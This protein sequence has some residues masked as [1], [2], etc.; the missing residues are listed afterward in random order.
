MQRCL[1]LALNGKNTVSPNPMVGSVIVH[2]NK[3]IGEGWH[4]RAG[5]PHAEVNAIKSVK[6][7]ALLK[8]STL[9]VS[10]EPC[11]HQGKTPPC[12]SLI[13]EKEIPRVVVACRDVHSAVNGRGIQQLRDHGVEVCEGVLEK[14]ALAL[15]RMFFTFHSQKRPYILL[16]WAQTLDGFLDRKREAHELGINWITQPNTRSYVH[17]VRS[18]FDAILVGAQTVENDNPQLKITEVRNQ[19]LLRLILDPQLRVRKNAEVYNDEHYRIFTTQESA[20]K[21]AVTLS[22]EEPF[23]EQVLSYCYV[24]GIQSV[25]VE[26]GA[27]TLQNFLDQNLWN[28]ALVLIG[29]VTFGQGLKAPALALE[30]RHSALLGKDRILN[31]FRE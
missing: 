14:E 10:L 4:Y 6:D 30:A 8:E 25:L 17:Q 15:N 24:N 20:L 1:Q 7:P 3:I 18:S 26:G 19:K 2:Q 23:L 29:D 11:S 13:I 27:K 31:Y 9:Y 12:S 28:E 21:Q 5:E 16:K 22:E